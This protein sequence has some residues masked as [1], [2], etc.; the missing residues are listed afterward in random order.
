MN[1]VT[2]VVHAGPNITMY[3]LSLGLR[4]KELPTICIGMIAI[5]AEPA[6]PTIV[7][8]IGQIILSLGELLGMRSKK[9]EIFPTKWEFGI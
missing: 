9:L 2:Q 1:N 7:T 8:F 5:M 3:R 4:V 6:T